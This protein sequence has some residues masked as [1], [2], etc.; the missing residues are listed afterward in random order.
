MA[1]RPSS[2][3]LL[4]PPLALPPRNTAS[5]P[6]SS[7]V[8]IGRRKARLPKLSKKLRAQRSPSVALWALQG[9]SVSSLVTAARAMSSAAPRAFSAQDGLTISVAGETNSPSLASSAGRRSAPMPTATW[10]SRSCTVAA[11]C[12]RVSRRAAVT[13]GAVSWQSPGLPTLGGSIAGGLPPPGPTGTA[14]PGPPVFAPGGWSAGLP[15]LL[16]TSP[17][18][19]TPATRVAIATTGMAFCANFTIR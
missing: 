13:R 12:S 16:A 19:P 17:K 8:V 9:T 3:P 15:P 14:P 11:Y 7:S 6:S 10:P 18:Q 2:M 4:K 5:R 1:C